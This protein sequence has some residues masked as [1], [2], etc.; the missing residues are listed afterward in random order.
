MIWIYIH[1]GLVSW[2]EDQGAGPRHL[3][4]HSWLTSRMQERQT[5]TVTVAVAEGVVKSWLHCIT[6]PLPVAFAL[7]SG[8]A[9][10]FDGG[11]DIVVG[12]IPSSYI[13]KILTI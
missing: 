7:E 1:Y 12:E 5:G 11:D 2:N 3:Q 9:I 8:P 13:D 10:V 6:I 4:A